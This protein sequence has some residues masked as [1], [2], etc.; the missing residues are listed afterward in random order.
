MTWFVNTTRFQ[1]FIGS[2]KNSEKFL[3]PETKKVRTV[4]RNNIAKNRVKH[5]N[6]PHRTREI[7]KT[8]QS[9]TET[10]KINDVTADTIKQVGITPEIEKPTD[11]ITIIETFRADRNKEFF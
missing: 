8:T 2:F 3:I 1:A 7:R 11:A 4:N 9:G 5:T 6:S 10:F